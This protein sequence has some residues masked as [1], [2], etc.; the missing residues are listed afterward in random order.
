MKDGAY[1]YIL[2]ISTNNFIFT[3]TQSGNFTLRLDVNKNGVTHSF[4]NI[5]LEEGNKATDWTPA[6]E[7]VDASIA[8]V[9]TNLNTHTSNTSNPHSVTKAQ[10]GLSDVLNVASYSK[11]ESDNT[12]LKLAGGTLSGN[13]SIN[14]SLFSTA[15]YLVLGQN[16]FN[17]VVNKGANSFYP[18]NTSGLVDLGLSYNRWRY[19]YTDYLCNSQNTPI[20]IDAL[21]HSGND[22]AGSGLD[23]DTLDGTHLQNIL[24]RSQSG[25]STSGTATGWF[26][27]GTF[28]GDN[29]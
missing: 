10:V 29:S 7:D 2:G 13:L 15:T 20:H 17:V 23:A 22:G 6:P 16:D 12:F 18:N 4:W 1:T 14:T 3:P 27:I 28:I 19:L 11:T 24:E 9:Q 5:K 21:W 8:L 25:Y 26:R